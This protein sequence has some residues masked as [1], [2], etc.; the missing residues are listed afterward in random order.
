MPPCTEMKSNHSNSWGVLNT[1]NKGKK[2]SSNQH[3][4]KFDDKFILLKYEY[5]RCDIIDNEEENDCWS[6]WGHCR[7]VS[8]AEYGVTTTS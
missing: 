3:G 2:H 8:A 7:Q 4:I 6:L 5:V 1:I